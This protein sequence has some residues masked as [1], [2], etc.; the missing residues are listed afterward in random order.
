MSDVLPSEFV[1]RVCIFCANLNDIV[2]LLVIWFCNS[3][4]H[5]PKQHSQISRLHDDCLHYYTCYK[6][7]GLFTARCTVYR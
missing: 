4:S 6:L 2:M 5:N 1:Q 7:Q 3:S